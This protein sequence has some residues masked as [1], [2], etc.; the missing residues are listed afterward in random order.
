MKKGILIILLL[1]GAGV[2]AGQ[3]LSE[4]YRAFERGAKKTYADFRAEANARY[5]ESL[6]LVNLPNSKF[7]SSFNLL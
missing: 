3:S 2:V 7:I 5:A 6:P 4:R 1:A